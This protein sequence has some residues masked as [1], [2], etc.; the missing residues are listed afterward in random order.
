MPKGDGHQVLK[1]I[2]AQDHLKNLPV[3][4]LTGSYQ[5]ADVTQAYRLAATSYLQKMPDP[6]E[7][8]VA[9]R[10]VLKY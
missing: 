6:T 8:A 7:F 3:V 10:I 4:V 1:W 2:R 9:V 5:A